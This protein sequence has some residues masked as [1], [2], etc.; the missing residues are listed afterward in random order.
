LDVLPDLVRLKTKEMLF[1]QLMSSLLGSD[2]TNKLLSCK[3]HVIEKAAVVFGKYIVE[4]IPQI[5]VS[6]L[7]RAVF[8]RRQTDES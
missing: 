2:V 7:M 8:G 1:R 5:G 6:R 3:L 4:E